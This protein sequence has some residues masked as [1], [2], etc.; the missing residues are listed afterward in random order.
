MS[1]GAVISARPDQVEYLITDN[2]LDT[3]TRSAMEESG[4]NVIAVVPDAV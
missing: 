3:R 2:G 1:G 4:V